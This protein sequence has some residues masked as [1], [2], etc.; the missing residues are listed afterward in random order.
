MSATNT[1]YRD[2]NG[3]EGE[4][5]GRHGIGRGSRLAALAFVVAFVF[6]LVGDRGRAATGASVVNG[7]DPLEVLS[8]KIRPNVFVVLDSSGSM[9]QTVTEAVNTRSGDSPRSKLYQA[10]AVMRQVVQQNQ[11]KASFLFGTYTQLDEIN[12]SYYSLAPSNLNE[13]NNRFQYIASSTD[14]PNMASTELIVR[15]APGDSNDR[16]FQ[17]WQIIDAQW[18]TLYFDE[19]DNASGA[20]TASCAA[21]IPGPYPRFFQTGADLAAALQTAMNNSGCSGQQNTYGVSYSGSSGRFTFTRTGG[22]QYWRIPWGAGPNNIRNALAETSAS[23]TSYQTT[24][25]ISTDA[26]WDLLYRYGTANS[27][28]GLNTDY[29][30]SEEIPRGSG[31]YVDFYQLRA[32]RLWN[33]ETIKVQADGTI[34]DILFPTAADKT[35]PPSVKLQLVANGCGADQAGSATF[36]FAGASFAANNRSCRGFQPTVNL[37]PCDLQSPPAPLQITTIGPFL[38]SEMRF[39]ADGSPQDYSETMDGGWGGNYTRPPI[40]TDSAKAT[41]NTPIANTLID[42]LG[43]AESSGSNCFDPVDGTTQRCAQRGFDKLWNVGQSGSTSS[44]GTPPY[45]LDAIKDHVDPKEKT[46]VLFVTDGDDTCYNRGDG[47]YSLGDDNARRAAYWAEKLYTRKVATDPASSVETFVIGFGGGTPYRLDWIAWGGSGL[48]QGLTGQPNVPVQSGADNYPPDPTDEDVRWS[49]NDASFRTLRASCTTC[50]DAFLAPDADTLAAQLQAI[51]DQGAQVGEFSAQQSLTQSVFEYADVGGKD[52]AWPQIRPGEGRYSVLV[53][54]KMVSTFSL[55]GF[56]GQLRAY[57]ND[58]AGNA[59]LKWSAGDVLYTKVAAGMTTCDTT[60]GGGGVGLC[61]FVQLHA[62]ATDSTIATSAAAIKRRVYTTSRN[63]VYA[64][65]P[66]SLIAGTA[67]DRVTLWP[68]ESSIVPSSYTTQGSLDIE[69]GL[70][71]DSPT[72]TLNPI[73]SSC[74]EQEFARLQAQFEACVGTNLPAACTSGGYGSRMQAARREAREMILAFMAG[75]KAVPAY[76]GNG[77]QRTSSAVSGVPAQA[78]LYQV[79]EW[80]LA[81]STLATPAVIAPPSQQEPATYKDPEYFLFRD[82][83]RNSSGQNPDTTGSELYQGFGLRQPDQDGTVTAVDTPDTRVGLKPAA[84]VVFSPANDMLHAFRAGPNCSP[85]LGT[86]TDAGGEELWGFVPYDQLAAVSARLANDPQGRDNHVYMLARGVR[87][88]DVFVPKLP[89]PATFTQS[90][91]GVI[92]DLQG[93]WRRVI[94]FGRGIGGKY[95]TALDVTGLGPYTQQAL[96]MGGPIPL[97]SRGNPDSQDGTVGGPDNGS[98]LDRIYYSR[99]GETW[100]LPTVA[101]INRSGV[102]YQTARRPDGV[103]FVLFMGSGYGGPTEGSTFYTLDALSGDVIGG[104]DVEAAASSAGLSRSLPY[105]NSIVANV[106]GFNP[107][108]FPILHGFHPSNDYVRR[109]YFGDTYGRLWKVLTAEPDVAIPVADLGADQPVGT[110]VGLL[111]MPPSQYLPDGSPSPT[112]SSDVVPY[113]FV[114]SG[115]DLRAD[116]PFGNYGFRDDGAET[117]T[118]VGAPVSPNGVAT[119]P[120]V[121]SLFARQFD[122]GDPEADCGYTEEAVFRGTVQ[123]ATTFECSDAACSTPLGRVFFAGTRLSLPNTKF[124][125]PTPFACGLGDYPCRSQFDSIIY[126]LGAQTGQA[127]YDLNASGDDAYRIFRD[128]RIVA[129]GMQADPA[130]GAGSSTTKDEGLVKPS[131]T[132]PPPPPG[133]PPTSQTATAS[134]VMTRDPN[135]PPPA[136]RYGSTVCQ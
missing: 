42:I 30:F 87:F 65:S 27:G 50:R 7:Q 126:A 98:A 77:V 36:T 15:R 72:C 90:I 73:Y 107:S 70:P 110:A 6:G 57:Q 32:G 21:V 40:F 9:T 18:N 63:G 13:G 37:I 135:A 46:I 101:F 108:A 29:R 112:N 68:P 71:A 5:M 33:G 61:G 3:K 113:V 94:F 79:R 34:C 2:G 78:I 26:P 62:N 48:G 92:Y 74:A 10:K 47:G 88:A 131:P 80:I 96:K 43:L 20:T 83:P 41:G 93:V 95:V 106:V 109:L 84:T 121:V 44:S 75:A 86:C 28:T 111:G 58:G 103:E 54:T 120:P 104:A 105:S 49:G 99:M 4:A 116:G 17:S 117:D 39:N 64:Y 119:F 134:V 82:G 81:D 136:V 124:A 89:A 31:T 127:A 85:D 55:P 129:V 76:G 66:E 114:S 24:G 133:D 1:T 11:D 59:V 115:N 25:S 60:T 125:P 122:Q 35:N 12:G 56:H 14:F 45:Q 8:L 23:T 132:P 53:P 51:I 91:G 97:W 69:L 22:T 67:T 128:S 19:D 118:S 52:A 100:S 16:G 123:P 130:Q 38:Q 102:L